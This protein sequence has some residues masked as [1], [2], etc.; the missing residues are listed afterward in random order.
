MPPDPDNRMDLLGEDLVLLS[1]RP[2]SSQF[3]TLRINCGLM[4]S[5]LVRLAAM[6]RIDIKANRVIIQDP[7]P[8]GDAELDAA[9]TSLAQAGR[10]PRPEKWVGHSRPGIRD[11]YLARLAAAGAVRAE[12]GTRLGFIPVTRW[13]I[14]DAGRVADSIARLDA[15][16]RSTG[17]V[18]SAQAAYAGLA[19]A[20]ELDKK[21]YRGWANRHVRKRLAQIPE[22]HWSAASSSA[23]SSAVAERAAVRAT[24]AAIAAATSSSGSSV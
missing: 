24:G 17:Q 11:A 1:L 10:P 14:A 5:E 15:I 8:T 23:S 13:S 19:N 4:G 12:Q 6:G 2:E 16:A 9:L 21:L 3:G 18:D 22:G 20:M 7:A